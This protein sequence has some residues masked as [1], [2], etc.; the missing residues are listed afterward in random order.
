MKIA[1]FIAGWVLFVVAQAQN[2][3][4]STANG[5]SGWAGFKQWLRLQAVNLATRAFFSGLFYGFIVQFITTKLQ[6]AGFAITSTSIAGVAGYSANA[7]L[8]QAFGLLPW[9]RVE[10]SDLA[11]PPNPNLP[12]AN[13]GVSP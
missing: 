12:T 2:S 11:P 4:R 3:I 9:M 13:S 6:A 8:Y 5:L 10:V 1:V 7:L